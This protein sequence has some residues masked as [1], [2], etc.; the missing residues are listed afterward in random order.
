MHIF[1]GASDIL[2]PMKDIYP[3]KLKGIVKILLS[4]KPKDKGKPFGV[5]IRGRL[6]IVRSPELADKS[7]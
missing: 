3:L 4:A 1:T 6:F 5:L 2:F 7:G